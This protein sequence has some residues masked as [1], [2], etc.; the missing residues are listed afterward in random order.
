MNYPFNIP[1]Q[2]IL[3]SQS[4]RRKSLLEGMGIPFEVMVIP[5]SEEFDISWG[6]AKI[7][8]MLA[9]Q[10]ANC[11]EGLLEQ[12]PDK[13]VITAD[14]IVSIG[15]QV[16]NKPADKEEAFQ[17]LQTLSGKMHTVFTGVSI[18]TL[19][20]KEAFVSATDVYFNELTEVEINYYIDHYQPYDKAGS[21]GVQEWMGYVGIH[22]IEGCFFNV[23][24]LPVNEV[25]K[26]L[27]SY[28]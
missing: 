9:I 3:G 25:Y 19:K 23:M 13:L 1:Y 20:K 26:R 17:M 24:G 7:A 5:T 10:K 4:P 22:R 27:K 16:L 11:F 14:T 8:T 21:Y 12:H 15:D 28:I 2:I 18:A 6:P